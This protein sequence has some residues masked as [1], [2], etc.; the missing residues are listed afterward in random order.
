MSRNEE[1]RDR[2]PG[3]TFWLTVV[4]LLPL[5]YV[6]SFGPACWIS[7]RTNYGSDAI[8][9]IYAPMVK[10]L[11]SN[12][13]WLRMTVGRYS[14]FAAAPSWRWRPA[15]DLPILEK[16]VMPERWEWCDEHVLRSIPRRLPPK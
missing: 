14:R 12:R 1:I 11:S 8:P 7:S 6:V 13:K 15:H 2:K 5:F 16:I 10:C 4:V 3:W 9:V